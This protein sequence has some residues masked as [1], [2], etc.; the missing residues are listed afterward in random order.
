[1]MRMVPESAGLFGVSKFVEERISRNDRAL[2]DSDRTIRPL[3]ST[4]KDTMPML[5]HIRDQGTRQ[6]RQ[7]NELTMLVVL[8]MEE[9]FKLLTTLML[10]EAS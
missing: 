2:C 1:M 6:T 8:N 4:L 7:K 3:G 5:S 9:S 10:N